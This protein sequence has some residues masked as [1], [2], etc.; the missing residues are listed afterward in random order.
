MLHEMSPLTRRWTMVF[1][2]IS[3]YSISNTDIIMKNFET[4]REHNHMM[5]S[6][7]EI[8]KSVLKSYR[9]HAHLLMKHLFRKAVP[10]RISWDEHRIVTATSWKSNIADLINAMR[11]KKT[12]KAAGKNQF[13]RLL[14]VLNISS[15]LMKNKRLLSMHDYC[16]KQ[17][18][19]STLPEFHALY[20]K[21]LFSREFRIDWI[22]R[23]GKNVKIK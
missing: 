11:E 1:F 22:K 15:A 3:T 19:T 17:H 14:H 16:C 6:I 9:K 12:V 4:S 23:K 18:K 7:E 20:R 13:T 21:V 5:K 10:D 8:L 2:T